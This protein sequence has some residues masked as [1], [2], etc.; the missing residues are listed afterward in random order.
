M[1]P[2]V[3]RLEDELLGREDRVDR[4]VLRRDV[5][6]RLHQRRREFFGKPGAGHRGRGLGVDLRV[7]RQNRGR[8]RLVLV[9]PHGRVAHG[10]IEPRHHVGVG[11]GPG[12]GREPRTDQIFLADRRVGVTDHARRRFGRGERG[13]GDDRGVDALGRER[14]GHVGERHLD[15]L[16]R[17]RIAAVL[18]DPRFGRELADVLE[19]VGCDRLAVEILGRLIGRRFVDHQQRGRRRLDEQSSGGDQRDRYALLVRDLERGEVREA[20]IVRTRGHTGRDGRTV[21]HA[22]DLHVEPVLGKEAHRV[23]IECLR[24]RVDRNR[25]DVHDR[26]GLRGDARTA[27]K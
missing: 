13:L 7:L 3:G 27:E 26:T 4:L 21:R 14:A 17:R 22:V 24:S 19:P 9:G 5:D 18:V 15:E 12:A 16:H 10:R 11:F 25:G 6:R 1:E 20:D 23:G 2:S 8:L